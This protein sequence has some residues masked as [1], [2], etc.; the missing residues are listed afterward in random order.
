MAA[1]CIGTYFEVPANDISAALE[2]Y[3]PSNNRSQLTIT[4]DNK[5]VV[6]AYNAN[7]TSMRAALDNFRLIKSE[8]KMCILGQMGELGEVSDEEHQ[9]V[10]DMLQEARFD[11]VWLVGPAFQ[12]LDSP[13]RTFANV[14]EVKDA[15]AQQQPAGR[16]ILIKGSNSVK[17]FQLPELL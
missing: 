12:Q 2:A 13:F 6:D 10:I 11:E 15:I 14:D 16:Y 8:H 1:A 5:L 9:K 7:P 4:Q 3:T 17:L